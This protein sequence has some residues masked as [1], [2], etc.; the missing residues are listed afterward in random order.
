MPTSPDQII[1]KTISMKTFIPLLSSALFLIACSNNNHKRDASGSFEAK[2]IIVSAGLTGKIISLDIEEGQTIDSNTV[3]GHIDKEELEIQKQQVGASMEALQEKTADASPQVN[4]LNAQL[5]LQQTQLDGLLKEKSRIDKLLKADAAT[6]KQSDEINNQVATVRKQMDVTRKQI[7]VQK[8]TVSTQN[9]TV[10]S[11]GKPL[12]KKVALLEEQINDARVI[13]PAKGTILSK[14]AEPGEMVTM[15]KALYKIANLSEL[16]LRAYVTGDQFSQIKM[17]Q[18]VKVFVDNGEGGFREYSGE[19]IW[20]SGKAEFTPK[21]IQT[22]DERANLVYAVKIRVKNDG[23]L[24]IG[25]YGEVDFDGN[26][27]QR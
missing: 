5:S 2:E 9:K 12:Q 11:E 21:T 8:N 22:K 25:M 7:D 3:V 15:G 10:L 16:D 23:F 4:M 13:N 18:T 6:Q 20:I 14:Y 24:K 27:K 17:G 19:L 1:S 26:E